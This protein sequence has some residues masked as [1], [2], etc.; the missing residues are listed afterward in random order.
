M[1]YFAEIVAGACAAGNVGLG[2]YCV[3]VAQDRFQVRRAYYKLA[4]VA[5]MAASKFDEAICLANDQVHPTYTELMARVNGYQP[6]YKHEGL[7]RQAEAYRHTHVEKVKAIENA[8]DE[9]VR[10]MLQIEKDADRHVVALEQGKGGVNGRRLGNDYRCR[11]CGQLLN[12]E[13]VPE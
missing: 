4:I 6:P 13:K 8:Y 5:R 7:V 12:N 10:D 1:K 11:T 3:R 2:I 9:F